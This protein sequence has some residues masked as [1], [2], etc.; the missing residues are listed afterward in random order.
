MKTLNKILKVLF[1]LITFAALY[2]ATTSAIQYFLCPSYKL[3]SI[4]KYIIDAFLLNFVQ[5]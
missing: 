2:I 3:L 4:K 1:F 5:C